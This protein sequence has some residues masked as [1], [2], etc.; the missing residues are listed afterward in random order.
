[1]IDLLIK[2]LLEMGRTVNLTLLHRLS[3]ARTLFRYEKAP[4]SAQNMKNEAASDEG[5]AYVED[6]IDVIAEETFLF[7]P[8]GINEKVKNIGC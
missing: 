2:H 7:E 5:Q 8:K 1:M 4:Q 3:A 6:I